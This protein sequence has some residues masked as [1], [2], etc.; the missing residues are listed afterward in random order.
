[1]L[2]ST[3]R[4]RAAIAVA[5]G[6]AACPTLAMAQ[7]A[8]IWN[9]TS[10]KPA[11]NIELA[12]QA[13]PDDGRYDPR[14]DRYF[15]RYQPRPEPRYQNPNVVIEDPGDDGDY[16]YR[17]YRSRRYQD[18][19]DGV[20]DNSSRGARPSARTPQ[21]EAK[22]VGSDG[23]GQPFIQPATPQV[24]AFNAGYAPGSIV[25][26]SNARRLYFV[27][28]PMS[29]F[30]YPIGVGRE[31]FS[32][33]GFE[34]VSRITDWP[35]WYPPAEMRKRKPELPERMLGGVRNPLGAKAIYLGNTLYRIHGTN[36]PKSIGKA[37]SSGCFRMLNEHVL[38]L[39]S[40]VQV[41]TEVTVVKSLV[42]ATVAAVT[43]APA[44]APRPRVTEPRVIEQVPPPRT[45]WHQRPRHPRWSDHPLP[46]LRWRDPD[47][48]SDGRP[49]YWR[50]R[51]DWEFPEDTR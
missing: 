23:G 2:V 16:E 40:L 13:D 36:D 25:I 5:S 9:G 46:P 28:N 26:D 1:M 47:R 15:R 41:G 43:P 20:R 12:Q 10:A 30:A 34:K 44:P 6:L 51:R 42:R 21:G 39:A 33:T 22:P 4:L 19:N 38:H 35:D 29:A 49:S 45:Q 37:E 24:V 18:P 31:G 50:N 8:G 27:R 11:K 48:S 17:N 14:Y 3:K 7:D 32:W